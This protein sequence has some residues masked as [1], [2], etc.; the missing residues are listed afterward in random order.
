MCVGPKEIRPRRAPALG[1]SELTLENGG[2]REPSREPETVVESEGGDRGAVCEALRRTWVGP[3]EV[4]EALI[5]NPQ[6]GVLRV[7]GHGRVGAVPWPQG[8]R[9]ELGQRGGGPWMGEVGCHR[10]S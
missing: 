2:G 10:Q 1:P 7:D 6:G 5:P 9:V 3:P 4:R 8:G